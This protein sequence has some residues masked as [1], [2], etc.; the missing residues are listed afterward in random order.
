MRGQS[1]ARIIFALFIEHAKLQLLYLISFF[2]KLKF[3]EFFQLHYTNQE[4]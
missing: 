4:L 1:K 2:K 3:S